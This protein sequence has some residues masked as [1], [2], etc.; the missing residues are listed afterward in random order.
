MIK[1]LSDFKDKKVLIMGLGTK[2]GGVESARFAYEHGAK[3]TIT[4]LKDEESLRESL[5]LVKDIPKAL[6]LGKHRETDFQNH[7]IIIKNPGI[8]DSNNYIQNALKNGKVV[9][10]PIGIFSELNNKQYI[11]I[12]GT[13]GKSYTTGLTN[14]LLS[15][16]GVNSVAAGNNCVSPLSYL[17]K[18]NDFV[19]E[20]SSWQ[21]RELNK[22]KKSPNIA[23]W[24]NFFEDHLN[25]YDDIDEYFDDKKNILKHQNIDDYCILPL[26]DN[27][28]AGLTTKSKKVL[29]T[30]EEL[31]DN[32]LPNYF[33]V[34][35]IKD[36]YITLNQNGDFYKLAPVNQLNTTL[37]V[38]HHFELVVASICTAYYY[39]KEFYINIELNEN[40]LLKALNSYNGLEHR[41]ELLNTNS[42][43]AVINDSAASTPE[44]VMFAIESCDKLPITLI[45]GGGGHKNLSFEKLSHRLVQSNINVVLYRN[46][47]TSEI[48]LKLLSNLKY[49][50]YTI[51][52][53]L[54]EATSVGLK[55][56]QDENGT[57]LL[58]S[59]CSGAPYFTDMFERGNL[60]KK[61]V[62]EL[63]HGN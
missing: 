59:G 21:L 31:K 24:L 43:F 46:D 28:I 40:L 34:C 16:L 6:V 54:K 49:D 36:G 44:S 18:A 39:I 14:H 22:H 52:D 23:C 27:R 1:S 56:A 53:S 35:F 63:I 17:G 13:K 8:K 62:N 42:N 57:L 4:D 48:I 60:F 51:V 19:L 2:G 50:N 15:F 33:A 37:R 47:S 58:S 26:N 25:F 20:M 3:I 9:E 32:D 29:F 30:S 7:D 55:K 41:F 5:K 12:T 38:S 10:C 61:Y 11:G 45:I